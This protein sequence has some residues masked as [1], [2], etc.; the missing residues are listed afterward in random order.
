M[1]CKLSGSEPIDVTWILINASP[2]L[3][4]NQRNLTFNAISRK[5][6]GW[7]RMNVNNGKECNTTESATFHVE[8]NCKY[9]QC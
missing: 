9:E 8:V 1:M 5:E 4:W 2:P 7:Y 3:E 6:E